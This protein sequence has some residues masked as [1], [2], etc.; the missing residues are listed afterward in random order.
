MK[1]IISIAVAVMLLGSLL[2]MQGTALAQTDGYY[3]GCCM[4]GGGM[5]WGRFP[6]TNRTMSVNY[7]L[8]LSCPGVNGNPEDATPTGSI[9]ERG[10]I[11]INVLSVLWAGSN[12]FV[13]THLDYSECE[14][15]VSNFSVKR[16]AF[17]S[18]GFNTIEGT[19]TGIYNYVMP[20]YKIEFEFVDGRGTGL[21]DWAHIIIRNPLDQIVLDAEGYIVAGGQAT[22]CPEPG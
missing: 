3:E 15:N 1:G 9:Q 21:R 5:L 18:S 19:G 13:M 10:P 16:P 4:T 2:F 22:Y 8:L 7:G 6:P 20:G 14:G 11:D 17:F 12:R